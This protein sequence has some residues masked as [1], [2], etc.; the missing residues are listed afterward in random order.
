[1]DLNK[2]IINVCLQLHSLKDFY[3]LALTRHFKGLFSTS[4]AMVIS[5]YCI[6]SAPT[7]NLVLGEPKMKHHSPISQLALSGRT[8]SIPIFCSEGRDLKRQKGKASGYLG[9]LSAVNVGQADMELTLQ[10]STDQSSQ[11]HRAKSV[12]VITAKLNVKLGKRKREERDGKDSK[13]EGRS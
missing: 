3:S 10:S 2:P 12:V 11:M 1:L 13:Y 9:C 8:W 4:L 7:Q 5:D 6:D